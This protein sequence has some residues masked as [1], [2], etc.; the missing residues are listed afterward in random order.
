MTLPVERTRAVLGTREFLQMLISSASVPQ[1]VRQRAATLLRHYPT[2][3][4]MELAHH[5]C[6]A[7]FGKPANAD[8]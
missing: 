7:W 1:E 3:S 5:A 2:A 6:P 4:D 8:G